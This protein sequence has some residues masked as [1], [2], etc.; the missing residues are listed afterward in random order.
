MNRM[1]VKLS[2]EALLGN[3][4]YGVDPLMLKRVAG[5]LCDVLALGRLKVPLLVRWPDAC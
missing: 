2:G 3:A 5:E 4:D 1:L